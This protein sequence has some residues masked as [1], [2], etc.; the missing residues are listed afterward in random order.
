MAGAVGCTPGGA[1]VWGVNRGAGSAGFADNGRP[2]ALIDRIADFAPDNSNFATGTISAPGSSVLAA[3]GLA[4]LWARRPPVESARFLSG[5][6]SP[7]AV[8]AHVPSGAARC[9]R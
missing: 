7:R 5:R 1:Y 4:L 6:G 2:G 8:N 9:G 3:M